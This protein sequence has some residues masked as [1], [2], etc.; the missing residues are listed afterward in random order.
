MALA[1]ITTLGDVNKEHRSGLVNAVHA[2]LKVPIDDPT[3]WL[4]ST[5]TEQIVVAARQ[6]VGAIVV[7][8]TM[9]GGRTRQTIARLHASVSDHITSLGITAHKILCVVMESPP[10]N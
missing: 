9:F 10:R 7:E 1:Q 8:I 6:G 5:P 3:V 4:R 2:A